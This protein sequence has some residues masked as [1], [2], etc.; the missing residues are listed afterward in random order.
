MDT[1]ITSA[2]EQLWFLNTLV[3]IHL[4]AIDKGE[5]LSVLE[6]RAP[7]HDSPP[8]H[9]HNSEDELFI[10]LDGHLRLRVGDAEHE[11]GP[12]AVLMA[13]RSVPHTY[14]VDSPEGGR[15]ITVTGHGDFE[16]F[17]RTMGRPAAAAE[18]PVAGGPPSADAVSAL[19]RTA[20]RFGI[21]LVGPP[22]MP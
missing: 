7:L 16:R 13:P 6:H 3:T 4:S 11:A 2:R 15:W 10:V 9:V 19:S 12:G 14:C 17:V 21:Q 22:L 18:L 8:L 1:P 5:G 20:Q